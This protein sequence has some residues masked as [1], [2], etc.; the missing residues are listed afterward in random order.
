M[1]S[2]KKYKTKKGYRWMYQI[3]VKTEITGKKKYVT[4]GGF[5]HL[6]TAKQAASEMEKEISRKD[7]DLEKSKLTFENIFYQWFENYKLTTKE[8]TWVTTLRNAKNHILPLLGNKIITE[9][10]AV[11]IQD[12]VNFWYKKPLKNYKR[13]LNDVTRVFEYARRLRIITEN[14]ATLV[15]K[16]SAANQDVKDRDEKEMYYTL[17]ELKKALECLKESNNDQAYTFFRLLAFSGIRKGEALALKWSDV[18]FDKQTISITKTLSSGQNGW[19]I[20]TPKTKSS[21]RTVYI[22]TKTI[23]ILKEW[24]LSQKKEMLKLGYNTLTKE[25]LIFSNMHNDY[26]SPNMPRRWLRSALAPQKMRAIPVHG[27]RHTYAT[28]AIQGGMPPK[29]LQKQ[30]GHSD[31]RTTLNIYTSVTD[32]QLRKI[33]QRYTAFVNF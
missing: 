3:L 10:T 8:S 33:P 23:E 16:P 1:A 32:E 19:I 12:I 2:F 30:L 13:F 26:Q 25:Q 14:P 18:N 7:F 29:E 28:L 5:E 6:R 21:I 9:V 11:D 17:N 27:F 20:N 31:I 15:I 24:R 4:K 22:D